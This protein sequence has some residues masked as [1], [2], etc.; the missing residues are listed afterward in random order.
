VAIGKG[1]ADFEIRRDANA[2]IL[3]VANHGAERFDLSFSPAYS[4]YTVVTGAIVNN[5]P[6]K[7]SRASTSTDWHPTLSATIPAGETTLGFRHEKWFGISVPSPA[8][9]LAETSSNLKLIS[10]RWTA[11]DKH[12]SLTFSGLAGAKYEFGVLGAE[13]IVD[14]Q[15]AGKRASVFGIEFPAGTGYVHKQVEFELK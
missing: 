10:Q 8:P 5:K 11:G 2:Y 1:Y 9:K 4:H 7:F 13:N 12:L 6:I 14:T 15:G 3:R